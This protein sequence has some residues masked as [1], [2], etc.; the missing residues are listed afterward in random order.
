M[1]IRLSQLLLLSAGLAVVVAMMVIG[2]AWLVPADGQYWGIDPQLSP[3]A[4]AEEAF[5][6]GDYRFLGSRVY[7]GEAK[8]AEVVYG[9]S[10]CRNHPLGDG[11]A[12][13]YANFA[14]LR[15]EGAW[16]AFDSIRDYA[17]SYN[18]RLRDLLENNT[19]TKCYGLD[20]G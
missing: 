7:F 4:A 2:Y 9:I 17:D 1:M 18:F 5:A 13:T 8:E 14:E 6:A 20:V 16:D 12:A 10:R 3:E 19:D 15:G 11:G